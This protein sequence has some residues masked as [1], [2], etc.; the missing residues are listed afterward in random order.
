MTYSY[1]LRVAE[2]VT[3]LSYAARNLPAADL[4]TMTGIDAGDA[5]LLVTSESP[6]IGQQ[7]HEWIELSRELTLDAAGNLLHWRV[8]S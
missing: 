7:I 4:I 1:R 3:A 2:H 5:W 6:A 8:D